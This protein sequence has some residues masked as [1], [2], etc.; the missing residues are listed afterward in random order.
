MLGYLI[1]LNIGSSM[2]ISREHMQLNYS[3]LAATILGA[4]LVAAMSSYLPTL[5]AVSQ[6]PAVVLMEG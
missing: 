6:D 5:S 3:I 1:A 2:E 4:P